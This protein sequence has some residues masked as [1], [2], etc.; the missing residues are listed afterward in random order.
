MRATYL[1][2]CE[3]SEYQRR[4]SVLHPGPTLPEVLACGRIELVLHVRVLVVDQVEHARH[5]V[6]LLV[7]LELVHDTLVSLVV[8]DDR[9]DE[10]EQGVDLLVRVQRRLDLGEKRNE[11]KGGVCMW[12]WV[13]VTD[14]FNGG[15]NA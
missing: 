3:R 5:K 13:W 1:G 15:D 2:E 9:C 10:V 14:V 4:E 11:G 7:E 8:L 12:V 6:L